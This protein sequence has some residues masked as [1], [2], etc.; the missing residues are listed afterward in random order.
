MK[1]RTWKPLFR[2]SFQANIMIRSTWATATSNT[3]VRYTELS[4]DRFKDFWR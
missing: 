3:T 1:P 4:P 2:I